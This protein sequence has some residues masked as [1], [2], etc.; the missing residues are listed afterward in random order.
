MNIDHWRRVSTQ[1][2]LFEPC[3]IAPRGQ[4]MVVASGTEVNA[5]YVANAELSSVGRLRGNIVRTQR[6]SASFVGTQIH[7]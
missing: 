4:G 2:T 5:F 1:R 6:A 7:F 3:L